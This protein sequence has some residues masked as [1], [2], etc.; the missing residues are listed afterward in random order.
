MNIINSSGNLGAKDIYSLCMNPKTKKMKDVVDSRI[1]I[2]NWA[3]FE[4]VAKKTGEIQEILAIQTP[5]GE[6]YATNSAT[7]KEDF[8]N[9]LELFTSMGETV[10]AIAVT[11]GTS[12]AGREFITCVYSD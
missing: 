12:K 5:D 1:P 11:C 9:M 6:V 3:I 4:D 10:P 8:L 2:L 7:F